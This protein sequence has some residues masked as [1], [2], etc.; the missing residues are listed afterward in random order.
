MASAPSAPRAQPRRTAPGRLQHAV[1]LID[2]ARYAA[3]LR[4]RIDEISDAVRLLVPTLG[5]ARSLPAVTEVLRRLGDELG[6]GLRSCL[7]GR[8]VDGGRHVVEMHR[9]G[10][11]EPQLAAAVHAGSDAAVPG[12]KDHRQLVHRREVDTFVEIALAGGA[13]TERHPGNRI[14]TTNLFG[15]ANAGSVRDL[16]AHRA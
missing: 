5:P 9:V 3:M 13:F 1:G 4:A 10:V 11:F 15:Q 2:D 14:A 8:P 16:R 6:Q 12:V 7:A